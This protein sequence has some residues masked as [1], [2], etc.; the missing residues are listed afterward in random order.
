MKKILVP[1]DF[2]YVS[3]NALEYAIKSNPDAHIVVMH[4]FN[5]LFSQ[6]NRY[7][8]SWTTK[9]QAIYEQLVRMIKD[10]STSRDWNKNISIEVREGDVLK[11]IKKVISEFDIDEIYMGTRDKHD[12]IDKL[13]G[14]ITLSVVK[15]VHIPV[16]VIPRRAAY[17]QYNGVMV[18]ID[19]EQD[20]QLV[21]KKM[22]E[23]NKTHRSFIKFQNVNNDDTFNLRQTESLVYQ[24]LS[25]NPHPSPFEVSVVSKGQVSQSLLE[26]AQDDALDLLVLFS[27]KESFYNSI[28]FKSLSK[29]LILNTEL[30]LLFL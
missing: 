22:K 24:L 8:K 16:Y 30:P 12:I 14:T 26:I 17:T 2:S 7:L 9:S 4:V 29:E 1:V 20:F 23:W 6:Q 5:G 15:S 18:A 28:F 3:E 13:L 25:D 21:A 19:N 10:V 11:H 27:K